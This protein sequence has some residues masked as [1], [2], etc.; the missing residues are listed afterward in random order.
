MFPNDIAVWER[1]LDKYGSLYNGFFYDVMCGEEVWQHPRWEEQYKFD[2]QVLS[3]LRIDAVGDN[4]ARIDII[5]VKP[6]GNM[7]SI[8][9]LLT[10]KEQYIKEYQP[11]KPVR[12]VLVCGELDSN[13]VPLTEKQ[14]IAYIVV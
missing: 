5:E 10:Y 11:T 12:M 1:F 2:A 14:G 6:R 4:D 13:I 3:K 8:G 9:Q 7:A